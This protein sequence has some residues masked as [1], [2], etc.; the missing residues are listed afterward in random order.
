MI[1]GWAIYP[2]PR[3]GETTAFDWMISSA[4]SCGMELSIL[5]AEHVSFGGEEEILYKGES[6]TLPSFVLMRHQDHL[7]SKSLEQIGVRVF[8]TSK[9][10]FIARDKYLTYKEL[11]KHNISTPLTLLS[12]PN[13]K[14]NIKELGQPF[15]FKSIMG[16]KGEEVFLIHNEE[17]FTKASTLHPHFITQK[18][19]ES[20]YGRDIRLWVIG[21]KVVA[22][23]LRQNTKSFKSNLAGGGTATAY[24]PSEEVK[25]LATES[26]RTLGLELGGVDILFTDSGYTVCEVNSNAG[27]RAFSLWGERIDIP[28]LIFQYIKENLGNDTKNA[29]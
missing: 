20:S 21:Y 15:V 3:E 25:Q 1:H 6:M 2:T 28:L 22:T 8:N 29:W 9:S 13:Y 27:F 26:C 7:M 10:S 4:A 19:I 11:T 23:T 16:S 17:D 12:Q 18:Y 5:L 24:E 14:Q